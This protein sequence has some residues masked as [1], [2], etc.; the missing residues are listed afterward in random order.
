GPGTRPDTVS[1]TSTV[2]T[3]SPIHPTSL[4]STAHPGRT[5]HPGS[6]SPAGTGVALPPVRGERDVEQRRAQRADRAAHQAVI[7][8]LGQRCG[9]GRAHHPVVEEG[10]RHHRAD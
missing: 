3:G 1:P 6:T 2:Y 8:A 9:T 4:N 5:A 10:L 7:Q